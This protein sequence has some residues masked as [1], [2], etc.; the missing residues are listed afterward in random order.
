M[1][2]IVKETHRHFLLMSSAIELFYD[3]F[4]TI[5]DS[6]CSSRAKLWIQDSSCSSRAKLWIQRKAFNLQGETFQ[7]KQNYSLLIHNY[8]SSRDIRTST[9][10]WIQ[11]KACKLQAQL[12]QGQKCCKGEMLPVRQLCCSCKE[13]ERKAKR[14]F[15]YM[16]C[17]ED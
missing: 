1:F 7:D 6:S 11:R 4:M 17:R 16:L 8:L 12:L 2:R 14:N 5:Q 15:I 3:Y 9:L 13:V 10:L